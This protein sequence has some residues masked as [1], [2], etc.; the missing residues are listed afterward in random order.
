MSE[1]HKEDIRPPA[2]ANAFYPSTAEKLEEEIRVM[3]KQADTYEL[4]GEI[5]GLICPHAGYMYSGMVAAVGY[6]HLEGKN[7]S[8]VAIISPSHREYFPGISVFNGKGYETP[9]GLVPVASELADALI[10]QNKRIISSWAG[11]RDEHALEVQLPFLQKVLKDISIIPIVMGDQDYD[12]CFLLGESLATVLKEVPAIIV[13]SSDLSHYHPYN[14]AVKIDK[15][16]IDLV[17]AFDEA[18]LMDALE[19]GIC[20]ACGGG[21]I[22]AT[23]MASKKE[24]ANKS[25][26]LLYR[27]SGD[28]TGD[29]TAVVGYLSAAFCKLN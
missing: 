13:A 10:E 1:V 18:N 8:V 17:E 2:V 25:K 20:E 28:V 27:N 6:K 26:A 24:G 12:T 7:Y 11:H 15:V 9:L 5:K 29:Y 23:M 4:S 19:R 21:P 16:T 22:V 14:D 3:I